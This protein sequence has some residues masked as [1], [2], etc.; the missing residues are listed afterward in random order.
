MFPL[1]YLS[2]VEYKRNMY[3]FAVE[4]L[5]VSSS[6]VDLNMEFNII[7]VRI[8]ILILPVYT[9]TLKVHTLVQKQ[10]KRFDKI[11]SITLST[12]YLLAGT[13]YRN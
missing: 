13:A 1:R 12:K 2:N 8:A 10:K 3:S 4:G 6:F 5:N 11:P 9:L 7:F